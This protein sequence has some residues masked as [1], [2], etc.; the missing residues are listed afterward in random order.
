MCFSAQERPLLKSPYL[1]VVKTY[2]EQWNFLLRIN[3]VLTT[4]LIL[5]ITLQ[6]SMTLYLQFLGRIGGVNERVTNDQ[7]FETNGRGST[8]NRS[9]AKE[10]Q[11]KFE[12]HVL[13]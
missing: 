8:T 4:I 3:L 9:V 12:T 6:I 1:N 2:P 5:R 13:L 7:K 10:V 11:S